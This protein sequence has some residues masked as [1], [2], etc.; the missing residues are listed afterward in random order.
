MSVT[1][2]GTSVFQL[3][4]NNVYNLQMKHVE[5][6]LASTES[7][8]RRAAFIAIAVSAEGCADHM[9]TKLAQFHFICCMI[10]VD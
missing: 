4:V 8:L 10:Y 3:I 2:V 6:S 9:R 1:T 5:P 7:N